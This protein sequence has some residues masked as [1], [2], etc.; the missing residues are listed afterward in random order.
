MKDDEK[1]QTPE[2]RTEVLF[3]KMDKNM[4]KLLSLSEFIEGVKGDST[5][6][7]FLQCE[8]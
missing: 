4:D 5:I 1:E 3:E 2:K 8:I 6:V 7:K